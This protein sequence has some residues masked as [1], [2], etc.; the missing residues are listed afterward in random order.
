[1][2]TLFI[3][4]KQRDGLTIS[5]EYSFLVDN[6][7]E[8]PEAEFNVASG[9]F[10]AETMPLVVHATDDRGVKEVYYKVNSDDYKLMDAQ[11]FD[12]YTTLI[13]TSSYKTNDEVK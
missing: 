8:N 10:I 2:H 1:M 5:K 13:D 6:I 3:K 4:A 7:D 12:Y 9:G 11:G